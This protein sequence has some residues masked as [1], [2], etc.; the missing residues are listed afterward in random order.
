MKKPIFG[1]EKWAQKTCHASTPQ[2]SCLL[3]NH[4]WCPSNASYSFPSINKG[5]QRRGKRAAVA[6]TMAMGVPCVCPRR[7]L[8]ARRS[9]VGMND[10]GR[11][12]E[13]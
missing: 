8:G 9:L 7:L 12:Y 6:E 5:W 3:L 11:N 1:S 4:L 2:L 10:L 13:M